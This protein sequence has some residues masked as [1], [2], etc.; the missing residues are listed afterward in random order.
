MKSRSLRYLLR[1]GSSLVLICGLCG[2]GWACLEGQPRQPPHGPVAA[3]PVPQSTA[4]VRSIMDRWLRADLR[5]K[6][7]H[8]VSEVVQRIPRTFLYR[9]HTAGDQM[10]RPYR[11]KGVD[12]SVREA[13]D[14]RTGRIKYKLSLRTEN[15]AVGKRNANRESRGPWQCFQTSP[16]KPGPYLPP[17]K[18]RNYARYGALVGTSIMFPFGTYD[19]PGTSRGTTTGPIE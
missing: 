16:I 7:V 14:P 2:F 1:S 18:A 11:F 8:I 12:S 17:E 3:R 9:E 5:V 4:S 19:S 10:T 15:V 13:F 6:S